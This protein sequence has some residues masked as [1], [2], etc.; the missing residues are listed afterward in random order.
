MDAVQK[1]QQKSDSTLSVIMNEIHK[2]SKSQ[3][4][5][6]CKFEEMKNELHVK[7]TNKDLQNQ[8]SNLQEIITA[9]QKRN[10]DT[11]VK[12]NNLQQY[13]RRRC[14]EFQGIPQTPNGNT[15]DNTVEIA[16]QLGVIIS[17]SDISILTRGH[18]Q[19]KHISTQLLLPSL[20]T[21]N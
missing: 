5:L 11:E 10:E 18:L 17:R 6:S 7:I 8:N 16:K 4:Y 15:D 21:R 20:S 1:S 13:R 12:L 2:I 3:E 14:L 9:L 19:V